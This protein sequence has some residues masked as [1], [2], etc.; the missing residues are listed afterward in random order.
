MNELDSQIAD[1]N[2]NIKAKRAENQKQVASMKFKISNA[3]D[4][5]SIVR[6]KSKLGIKLSFNH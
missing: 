5:E 3:I 6:K 1:L 2:T 4:S